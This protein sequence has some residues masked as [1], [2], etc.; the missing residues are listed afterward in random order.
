MRSRITLKAAEDTSFRSDFELLFSGA[1][2]CHTKQCLR[3]LIKLEEDMKNNI[4]AL[5]GIVVLAFLLSDALATLT[6]IF[7]GISLSIIYNNLLALVGIALILVA[8]NLTT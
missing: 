3:R 4:K 8:K 6:I 2:R 1:G 5:I 7:P